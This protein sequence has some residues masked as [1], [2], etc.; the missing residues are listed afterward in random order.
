MGGQDGFSRNLLA[1]S[2][3]SNTVMAGLNLHPTD[4]LE[5]GL[6]VTFSASDASLAPF[7]LPADD[8]VAIT[9]PMVFDFSTT[10]T[11]SDLDVTRT[12]AELNARYRFSDRLWARLGY[13]WIDFEDDAPYLY[14]T[15]GRVDVVTAALGWVF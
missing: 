6:A 9:P 10:H 5:L 4:K 13:L 3:T 14:D 7:D 12:E 11:N 8:Y 15:S 1:Y 2:S